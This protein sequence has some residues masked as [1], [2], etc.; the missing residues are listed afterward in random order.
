MP[1]P[2]DDLYPR[3][4]IRSPRYTDY[5]N[6]EGAKLF[7]LILKRDNHQTALD[8]AKALVA[9][10]DGAERAVVQEQ[11]RRDQAAI[12]EVKREAAI[13]SGS[14]AQAKKALVKKNVEAWIR[15]L[16]SRAADYSRIG[17]VEKQLAKD[18]TNSQ[19]RERH[20]ANATADLDEHNHL[21]RMA[22]EL[23]HDLAEAHL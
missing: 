19:D 2:E 8:E 16:R 21:E 18:A 4:Y 14:D 17:A 6:L 23:A 3:E 15:D 5:E 11:I 13:L 9:R 7:W 22:G 1:Q 20:E 10:L 12:D